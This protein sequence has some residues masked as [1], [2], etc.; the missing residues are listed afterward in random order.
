MSPCG[1]GWHECYAHDL[2]DV[3]YQSNGTP[4][5]AGLACVELEKVKFVWGPGQ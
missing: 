3:T 4:V 5:A 2:K 1:G